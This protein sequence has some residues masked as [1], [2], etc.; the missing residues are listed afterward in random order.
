MKKQ[1]WTWLVLIAVVVIVIVLVTNSANNM[2]ASF[3]GMDDEEAT[4]NDSSSNNTR[5]TSNTNTSPTTNTSNRVQPTTTYTSPVQSVTDTAPTV[6]HE[7]R[8]LESGGFLPRSVTVNL[9]STLY[10]NNVGSNSMWV[11]STEYPGTT[12]DICGTASQNL[13]FNQCGIGNS[14]SFTPS[15]RGV[16]TYYNREAPH[17]SATLI[18]Q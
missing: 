9:G 4:A 3:D 7:V 8:Y 15:V 11:I 2:P 10:F 13:Y 14:Y 18:V 17:H 16:W 12:M 1:T 5:T 6:S